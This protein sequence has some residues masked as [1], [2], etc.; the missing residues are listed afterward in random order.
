MASKGKGF[1]IVSRKAW[2]ARPP[3]NVTVQDKRSVRELFIHW[4]GS[5]GSLL[6]INTRAEEAAHMRADQNF[7]MNARERLARADLAGDTARA[8]FLRQEFGD[9]EDERGWSDIAYNYEVFPSGRVYRGRGFTHVPAG[10]LNHNA[11]TVAVCCVL[12]SADRE[13]PSAMNLTLRRFV[14]WAEKYATHELKV[15]GHGEVVNTSCPGPALRAFVPRL[16]RV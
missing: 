10:Q 4:P 8:T 14:A 6:H 16:D 12:G 3:R 5:A 2:G 15:R 13:I 9:Y 1:T 7:H 11:G